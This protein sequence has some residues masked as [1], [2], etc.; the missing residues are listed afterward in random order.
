MSWWND[1]ATVDSIYVR[2]AKEEDDI[3]TDYYSGTF[4]NSIKSALN[5]FKN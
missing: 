5:S 3:Y 4:F 1:E 2:S